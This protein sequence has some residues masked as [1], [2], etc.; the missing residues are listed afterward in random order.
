MNYNDE[1]ELTFEEASYQ[2]LAGAHEYQAECAYKE[3]LLIKTEI[4]I[5]EVEA[6][7]D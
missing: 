2:S 6:H 1:S 3:L 5:D 4:D 7:D